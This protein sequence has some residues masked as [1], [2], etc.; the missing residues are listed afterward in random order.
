MVRKGPQTAPQE[1][2]STA[3]F[4]RYWET[5]LEVLSH[6]ALTFAITNSSYKHVNACTL[7]KDR[8]VLAPHG[9]MIVQQCPRNNGLPHDSTDVTTALAL[10]Q[11]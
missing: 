8:S 7:K 3:R 1:K 4:T 10:K 9:C 2:I 5:P 6:D 11:S